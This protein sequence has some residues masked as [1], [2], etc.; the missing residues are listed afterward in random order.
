ML[1]IEQ[2]QRALE[3]AQARSEAV[4]ER[5]EPGVVDMKLVFNGTGV[6]TPWA[7]EIVEATVHAAMG[8]LYE[9]QDEDGLEPSVLALRLLDTVVAMLL[10][11]VYLGR[12]AATE[13]EYET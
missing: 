4:F 7:T 9:E 13:E 11:G 8:M 5:A 10:A 6:P 3:Q 1:S 12:A 2:A